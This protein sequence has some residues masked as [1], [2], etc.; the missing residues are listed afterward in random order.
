[1]AQDHPSSTNVNPTFPIPLPFAQR[2]IISQLLP[3]YEGRLLLDI[4]KQRTLQFTLS[5]IEE[6]N[7]AAEEVIPGT[8]TGLERHSLGHLVEILSKA[9]ERYKEG[10]ITRIPIS[11]RLYKFK[12]SLKEIE[13]KIWRRIL[14]KECTLDRF[15]LHLQL[16]MGWQ[17]CHHYQ[18]K[19]GGEIYG[20][21][22][23]LY[24]PNGDLEIID[25]LE[26]MLSDIVP[27]DGE[28][29]KFVYEYDF[30]DNWEHEILF[31]GC[32]PAEKGARYPLCTEGERACPPEDVGGA[33]G[34]DEYL[35]ALAD[36]NHEEHEAY[37]QWQGPFDPEKFDAEQI[38]KRMR[39]GKGNWRPS[40]YE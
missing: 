5:E 10:S 4:P 30:G 36:P 9:N 40:P 16:A 17:N 39:R 1:M 12:I 38:S 21:L 19:I 26:T 37:T 22:E 32:V 31:E 18:F 20:N 25:S 7:K 29:L 15:H 35:E 14:V 23:V 11:Q 27:Q 28:W 34:Y 13:P 2:R 3:H 6:I 24:D 33:Y 8:F